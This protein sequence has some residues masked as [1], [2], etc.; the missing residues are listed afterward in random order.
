MLRRVPKVMKVLRAAGIFFLN[1][2]IAVV[3]TAVVAA[4]FEHFVHYSE[5][6]R[7]T[8]L[9]ADVLNVTL[10]FVL[11]Y[12]AYAQRQQALAKWVWTAGVFWF[13]LRALHILGG[14]DGRVFWELNPKIS[15]I[16][17]DSFVSWSG[18]TLPLLRAISYSGGAFCRSVMVRRN[19]PN[20][21]NAARADDT[22]R[23]RG[24][25]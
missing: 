3:G 6:A 14:V 9:K 10:A 25:R 15:A 2:L 13:G 17:W 20:L 8:L 11:G 4:P 16:D 5:R 1:L 21:L 22:H 12:L 7:V 24:T 23:V 19:P 18:F